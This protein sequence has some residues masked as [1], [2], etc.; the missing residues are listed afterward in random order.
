M[1]EILKELECGLKESRVKLTQKELLRNLQTQKIITKHKN[2]YYLNDGY[3]F[4]RIDIT[5]LGNGFLIPFSEKFRQDL[6]IEAKDLQT[7]KYGDIVA[8]KIIN[9]K[10]KRLK[11]KVCFIIKRLNQ[12]I[13]VYTKKKRI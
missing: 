7:A 8:C 5:R 11:A 10:N 4:G 12:Y 9:K 3:V 1:K 13:L 6:L 2:T